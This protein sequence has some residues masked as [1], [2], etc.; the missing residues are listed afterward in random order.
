MIL[1]LV[2]RLLS[3]VGAALQQSSSA[4]DASVKSMVPDQKNDNAPP[5]G[6]HPATT[7]LTA[8][9]DKSERH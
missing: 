8:N 7:T 9:R 5:A 4:K 3:D 2:F 1:F 6:S